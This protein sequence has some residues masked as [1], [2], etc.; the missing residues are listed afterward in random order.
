MKLKPQELKFFMLTLKDFHALWHV[1]AV[2]WGK[3]KYHSAEALQTI[4]C[5][6]CNKRCN[7]TCA[8]KNSDCQN[9]GDHSC[10]YNSS[11]S[12]SDNDNN[13]KNYSNN[14]YDNINYFNGTNKSKAYINR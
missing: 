9:R 3:N 6:H 12:T 5:F 2:A 10:N 7:Y 11:Q 1:S 13:I 4:V 8:N 14:D